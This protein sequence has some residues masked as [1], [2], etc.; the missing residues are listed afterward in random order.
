MTPQEREHAVQQVQEQ[1]LRF[2]AGMFGKD[3]P[4]DKLAELQRRLEERHHPD[5]QDGRQG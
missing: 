3:L 5:G 2:V 4:P 1:G